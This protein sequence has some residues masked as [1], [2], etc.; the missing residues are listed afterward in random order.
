MWMLAGVQSDSSLDDTCL[1]PDPGA[2][3][4][5]MVGLKQWRESAFLS[6]SQIRMVADSEA[7]ARYRSSIPIKKCGPTKLFHFRRGQILIKEGDDADNFLF[8]ST[9]SCLIFRSDEEGEVHCVGSIMSPCFVG[10]TDLF[11]S[12][13]SVGRGPCG[14]HSVSVVAATHGCAFSCCSLCFTS[15]VN[16]VS[17]N[18]GLA[19]AFRFLSQ[20]QMATWTTPTRAEDETRA[21]DTKQL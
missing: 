18:S 9:G 17:S 16:G 8:V 12:G 19:N 15:F 13:D 1:G 10:I 21:A 2:P 20:S 14:R 3:S 6:L 5:A 4:K 7:E 11:G